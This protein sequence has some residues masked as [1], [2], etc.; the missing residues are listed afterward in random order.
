MKEAA[1]LRYVTDVARRFGWSCWHVPAPMRATK[2]GFVG[3]KEAA[4]LPDLLLIHDDPPRLVFAELKGTGGKL[5][6]EQRDFLR[7]AQAVSRIAVEPLTPSHYP[8]E[9][10]RVVGVYVWMPGDELLIE[11]IL[12]SRMLV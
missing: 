6:D 9:G 2:A 10:E 1:F 11:G 7:A 3:A 4:G 8:G 5:S 12:R